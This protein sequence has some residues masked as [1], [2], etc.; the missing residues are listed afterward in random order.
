[1]ANWVEY[2]GRIYAWKGATGDHPTRVWYSDI[3]DYTTQTSALQYFDVGISSTSVYI[4]GAWAVRDSILFCL[5]NDD[6]YA[7][8]GVPGASQLR[9]IGRYVG[10]AHQGAGVV[11]GN[12]MYF[13][14]P[15]YYSPCV[16]TPQGVDFRTFAQVKPQGSDFQT[17]TY[18][19]RAI[20]SPQMSSLLMTIGISEAG[21]STYGWY[22]LEYI[23]GAWFPLNFREASGH[24]V[25]DACTIA[26]GLGYAIIS[27]N[28]AV[29][30]YA[31]LQTRDVVL[32][33]PSASFDTLS[34]ETS[35]AGSV[36]LA[37]FTPD[38]GNE[39]RARNV[40][41]EGR[42]WKSSDFVTPNVD[43]TGMT[44][45]LELS[46]LA[47]APSGEFVRMVF[48]DDADRPF[49]G[50]EQ[51]FLT[52]IESFSIDRVIVEYEVR[53]INHWLGQESGT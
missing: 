30:R 3:D 28:S 24:S 9:F 17:F 12:E 36:T 8:T 10:P 31:V 4:K 14:S 53:P 42:Y 1:M 43:V 50:Y 49:T 22:G 44:P 16:A 21:A 35:V 33:R 34:D 26:N 5:S 40:I 25:V 27:S 38:P 46:T 52:D 6:W 18:P 47:D 45:D 2:R 37:P 11:L 29:N 51:V 13:L 41:V 48:R 23:N 7:Y 15:E 19:G 20:A 39:S 32:D